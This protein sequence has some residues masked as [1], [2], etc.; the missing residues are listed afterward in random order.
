MVTNSQKLINIAFYPNYSNP[1][2]YLFYNELRKYNIYCN[3]II[4]FSKDWLKKNNKN[5]NILHFHWP[6]RIWRYGRFTEN[7]R[8]II[9][10]QNYLR[11][12]KKLHYKIIWTVHNI[13]P[14]EDPTL[15]DKL[16]Q[17]VIVKNADLLITHS[18]CALNDVEEIYHPRCQSVIMPHG[19]YK[20]I[21]PEPRDRDSIV[22]KFNLDPKLPIFCCIGYIK[23]YKGFLLA[24]EA[25]A[26]LDNKAQLVVGGLMC[27]NMDAYRKLIARSQ[28]IT[29]I[30]RSLTEQEFS[31]II[32]VSEAVILPYQKITSSGVLLAAWSMGRAVIASNLPFFKE[33]IPK[34][35]NFGFLFKKGDKNDLALKVTNILKIS[36][37]IRSRA[38]KEQSA[39]YEWA[40]CIKPV[41]EKIM[42]II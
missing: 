14:H 6:E 35:S 33:M 22:R 9:F 31:D 24:C 18:A 1:Y 3:D 41:V 34:G 7:V 30:P 4:Q 29:L 5:L 25:F 12:S 32:S 15:L 40:N 2:L 37:H 42:R 11:F 27:D 26:E 8:S 36:N 23:R 21:Y 38:A 13:L 28:N 10:L 16:G 39:K 20:N 19:N 17:S